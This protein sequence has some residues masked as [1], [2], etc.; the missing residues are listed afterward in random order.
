M[1]GKRSLCFLAQLSITEVAV[2]YFH[3]NFTLFF[4]DIISQEELL[5]LLLNTFF[6]QLFFRERMYQVLPV[7]KCILSIQHV[8]ANPKLS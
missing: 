2:R 1:Q 8:S 5:Y 7:N 4:T 6:W 3:F